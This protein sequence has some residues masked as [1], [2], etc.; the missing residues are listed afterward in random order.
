[1]PTNDA[2][3]PA[4]VRPHI[5][6]HTVDIVQ[7]PGIGNSPIADMDALA[8]IVAA[9]LPTKHNTHVPTKTASDRPRRERCALPA[10]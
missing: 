10:A 8:A 4:H 3:I 1:M 6:V 2:A 7:P 5:G 9:A